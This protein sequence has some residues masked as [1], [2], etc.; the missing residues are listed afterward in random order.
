[1]KLEVRNYDL[2][3]SEPT[4]LM[5]EDDCRILSVGE[6][7]RVKVTGSSTAIAIVSVSDSL[8]R[9]GTVMVPPSLQE[10][11]GTSPGMQA[12]V[13]L[14]H[15]PDSVRHIRTKM[16]GGRLTADEISQLVDDVVAGRLSRVETAAWLTALYIKGMDT[17]EIA[18]YAQAMAHTGDEISFGGRQVFDFH[19]FGGL[20]GNKIT[21]IVVSIAV[22]AGLT[23]PKLS[24]RAISS[25]CGTADFV[26]TFCRVDLDTDE[27][28]RISEEVGGVFSWTGATDL[29][30]AG[31]RFITV[32]RPLG[33]DPRPQ[34]LASIMSKKV[35]AGATDLVMD[36]P[37]G[38]ESK[39][40]TL[41][42]ARS[43][44]RDLMDLGE[45]LGIRV[46]C[47]IT[48]A[49]Q[50]L[51]EAVGPILE[52]RECMQVLECLPG[53]EDVADKACICAGAMLA[54][55]GFGDGTAK[56]RELLESGQAHR[57]FLEIVAAQGGDAGITSEDMIPGR[58]KAE[59]RAERSGFVRHMSNKAI[60]AVA[61][62]A[63]APSEKGSGVVI[64]KKLGNKVSK[65]DVLLT[66]HSE[67]EDK[68]GH[69]LEVAKELEPI[70]VE[71]MIIGRMGPD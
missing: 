54:L 15:T 16:D 4:V 39:V 32:Q 35:A 20:P 53:H 44:A 33:I 67:R 42:M 61:K 65:G 11:S 47:M 52:A 26:E 70:G 40:P 10:A 57:R 21:P 46:E 59:V 24:S 5:H 22:A 29:G 30:P 8:V 7:D 58:Y 51:G 50:P 2:D 45:R 63:G 6:G 71:G 27:V 38:T 37:M 1:M 41:E 9:E 36:I 13:T 18:A 31:D 66:I 3:T 17:G 64:G 28:R 69:A 25:A 68:L 19:S 62:A 60:V 49:E 34:L 55:A 23:V 43:Y 12:E 48:Y 56:A 14:S